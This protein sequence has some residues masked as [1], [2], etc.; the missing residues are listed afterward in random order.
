MK[1]EDIFIGQVFQ[2]T[3]VTKIPG[4]ITGYLDNPILEYFLTEKEIVEA[5]VV[6]IALLRKKQGSY[7]DLE[8]KR[9]YRKN[10]TKVGDTFI[11]K[12]QGILIPINQR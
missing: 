4:K 10:G 9:E 5:E 3:K 12:K 1:N 7:Y 2:I 6:K 8:T 11:S